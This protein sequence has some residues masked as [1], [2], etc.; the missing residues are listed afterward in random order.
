MSRLQSSASTRAL[1]VM[2][3]SSALLLT[4]GALVLRGQPAAGSIPFTQAQA[5]DGGVVYT[6]KCAVCHG[7]RL[8]DGAATPL[9]PTADTVVA[10]DLTDV[11]PAVPVIE[12]G[13][14]V[15][16]TLTRADGTTFTLVGARRTT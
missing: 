11:A 12:A 15:V 7:S 9:T 13:T 4:V 6:Q 5:A 2:A 1:C 10:R 14:R 16:A 3:A 8:D